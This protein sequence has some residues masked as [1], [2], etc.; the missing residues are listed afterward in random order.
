MYVFKQYKG[1]K[2]KLLMFSLAHDNIK[3]I[4]IYIF[5]WSASTCKEV[6]TL[7]SSPEHDQL[8]HT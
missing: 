8:L 7:Y 5:I 6:G 4:Y 3:F 2:S 1:I